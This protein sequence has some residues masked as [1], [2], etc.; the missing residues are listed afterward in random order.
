MRTDNTA[1][2]TIRAYVEPMSTSPLRAEVR[3]TTDVSIGIQLTVSLADPERVA[4]LV[5]AWLDDVL[6]RPASSV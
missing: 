1:L 6:A 2:L 3:L 4:Q 5:R